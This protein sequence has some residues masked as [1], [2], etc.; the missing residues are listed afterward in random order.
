[1]SSIF[2]IRTGMR[3]LCITATLFATTCSAATPQPLAEPISRPDVAAGS[4]ERKA[5]PTRPQPR[6]RP[7]TL[8]RP[9]PVAGNPASPLRRI[10][11]PPPALGG[12]ATAPGGAGRLPGTV[13]DRTRRPAILSAADDP[14]Y[15]EANLRMMSPTMLSQVLLNS[16]CTDSTNP[17]TCIELDHNGE[18]PLIYPYGENMAASVAYYAHP[19]QIMLG[20][21]DY[22]YVLDR[23]RDPS[24]VTPLLMFNLIDTY[25]D[26]LVGNGSVFPDQGSQDATIRYMYRKVRSRPISDAA[27]TGAQSLVT[28]MVASPPSLRMARASG[29]SQPGDIQIDKPFTRISSN[30]KKNICRYFFL[31]D[32]GF[33]LY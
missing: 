27:L 30:D 10:A 9:K 4:V 32:G 6:P 25:C 20:G 3:Y 11:T 17:D 28:G 26:Q 12:I 2:L 14:A 23:N 13:F 24:G 7:G 31:I 21:I 16:F 18:N 8:T 19:Y 15:S 29:A 33:I 5:I 22:T 1:M